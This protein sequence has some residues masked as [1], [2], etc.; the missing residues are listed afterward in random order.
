MFLPILTSLLIYFPH[1]SPSLKVFE[2]KKK[3]FS[4]SPFSSMLSFFSPAS[5]L[6]VFYNC[7]F[8]DQQWFPLLLNLKDNFQLLYLTWSI[9]STGLWPELASSNIV[10][11]W[12]LDYA[13]SWYFFFYNLAIRTV[14][15]N[16][17]YVVN[18]DVSWGSL[19]ISHPL[20]PFSL[21]KLPLGNLIRPYTSDLVA[22]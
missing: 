17:M 21:N 1:I 12:L 10:L 19:F 16:F 11:P 4:L 20:T 8:K 2:G 5:P 9:C 6:P 22:F 3:S 14:L 18:I 15:G 13:L 7:L